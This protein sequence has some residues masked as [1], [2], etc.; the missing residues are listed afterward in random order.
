V[1]SLPNFTNNFNEMHVNFLWIEMLAHQN[2]YNFFKRGQNMCNFFVDKK[3]TP[4]KELIYKLKKHEFKGITRVLKHMR[5]L[6]CL[7]FHHEQQHLPHGKTR[8]PTY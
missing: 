7:N 3:P 8:S 1:L 2:V 4:K 6:S 5:C